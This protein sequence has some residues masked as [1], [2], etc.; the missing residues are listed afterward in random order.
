MK[1]KFIKYWFL[2]A[3]IALMLISYIGNNQ[4]IDW[5]E[6][7]AA[8]DKIPYGTFLLQEQLSSLFPGQ[9]I[10]NNQRPFSEWIGDEKQGKNLILMNDEVDLGEV[11]QQLLMDFVSRGNH[12]FIASNNFSYE[13]LEALDMDAQV[14]FLFNPDTLNY[15]ELVNPEYV[16]R[17]A[18]FTRL[19]DYA[20]L[21]LSNGFGGDVLGIRSKNQMPNFVRI[22][23][24][25]GEIYLHLNPRVFTNIHLLESPEYVARGLSYLPQGETIWDE[26]YKPFHRSEDNAF[27]LIRKNKALRYAWNL[28]IAGAILGLV[29]YAKRKQRAI[30]RIPAPENKSLE[31][32][33][34]I[35]DLYYHE[36]NH[37]DVIQK[38][39]RYFYHNAH[40]H[41]LLQEN[42]VNFWE[43][44]QQK[45]GANEKTIKK[46]NDMI[47]AFHT[48]K[49]VSRD[50]LFVLN[51][52]LEDFY[53]QSG[54]YPSHE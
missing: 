25:R 50:F 48:L 42:D 44:L 45:S 37:Q 38:K 43:K 52:H 9:E 19:N 53:A 36:G 26:Y 51:G 6:T 31:F 20:E 14:I 1:A 30:P 54:K 4:P 29:F 5:R 15:M 49:G 23:F 10:R 17:Q 28:L 7:Y 41:Y 11:D 27:Q 34:N 46:L 13:F 47:L 12:L 33:E 21:R 40:L 39:I 18:K 24:G 22:H 2:I 35:G 16:R 3:F 8:N 32:I